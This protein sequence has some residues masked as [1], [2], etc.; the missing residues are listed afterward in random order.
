MVGQL[1]SIVG[2]LGLFSGF[3]VGLL[4]DRIGIKRALSLS[5]GLLAVSAVLVALQ[6][7]V[8]MLYAAAVFFGLSFFAVYGLIPAYI[9]KTL[10][11]NK[12]TAVFAG[13][14][15]CLGVGTAFGKLGSGFIPALTGSLEQVYLYIAAVAIAAALL[16]SVLP[17]EM[18][19]GPEA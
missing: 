2:F 3:A 12:T 4:A 6:S 14:N 5:Y 15:I 11:E 9:T 10:D 18:R 13:A 1:W 16:V 19:G 8:G 7:K 17:G